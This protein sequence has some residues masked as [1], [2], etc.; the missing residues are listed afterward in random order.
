A[1]LA[2]ARADVRSRTTDLARQLRAVEERDSP[3]A[4]DVP[5]APEGL[6]DWQRDEDLVATADPEAWRS[7]LVQVQTALRD[8]AD[9][10]DTARVLDTRVTAATEAVAAQ[11]RRV[12][13][14]ARTMAGGQALLTEAQGSLATL[15]R[16]RDDA[17]ADHSTCPCRVSADMVDDG[18]ASGGVGHV[19]Q[20]VRHH[21]AVRETLRDL[22]TRLRSSDE[23][24]AELAACEVRLTETLRE[25]GFASTDEV[26]AAA[27]P[28]PEVARLETMV[29]EA[30]ARRAAAEQVLA[31]EL[32]HRAAQLPPADEAGAAQA[33]TEARSRQRAAQQRDVI[34][35]QAH[36]QLTGLVDSLR[37]S[38]VRLVPLVARSEQVSDLAALVTGVGADN[39]LRMRLSSFVLAARLE[40][41]AALAN[42]RLAVMGDGR[43]QLQHSDGLDSG[44]RRSG[45][46]LVVRDLWTGAVRDT[47]TLSGGESF[48]ASLALALGLADAVREEAGGFD[49]QTLF[50]DE[51]FGTLDD[52]SLEEVLTVLDGLREG[53]RAVGVVSHVTDLLTRIPTQICVTKTHAGSSVSIRTASR[54]AA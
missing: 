38:G 45:L 14:L 19:E 15:E 53:G 34:A 26:R 22:Q 41:V 20:A 7:E 43:Y 44:R 10:P 24:G 32:V 16:R 17:L 2:A 52:D 29:N 39:T 54:P 23:A 28:P 50:V 40:K 13:E 8:L 47:S 1:Q 4:P 18:S 37:A 25:R 21:C 36:Q 3:G 11:D 33:V 31:D 51:G 9:P 27:T 49:L 48:M 35:R 12:S 6:A 42:E 46:G 30:R 5:H